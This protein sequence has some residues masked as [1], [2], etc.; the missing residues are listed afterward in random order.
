VNAADR[1]VLRLLAFAEAHT[2][3]W[4]KVR[5]LRAAGLVEVRPRNDLGRGVAE[6]RITKAGIAAL[7][8]GAK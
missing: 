2:L 1:A 5:H 6:Y 3:D 8:S 7:L 4:M